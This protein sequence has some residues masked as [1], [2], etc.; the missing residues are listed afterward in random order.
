MMVKK[1]TIVS[2]AVSV[3]DCF[4]SVTILCHCLCVSVIIVLGEYALVT[5][6]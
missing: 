1:L 3:H 5:A 2:H 6:G 4:V